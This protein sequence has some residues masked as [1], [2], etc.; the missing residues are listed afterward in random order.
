MEHQKYDWFLTLVISVD[1]RKPTE[2]AIM[3]KCKDQIRQFE[4]RR[5]DDTAPPPL[6]YQTKRVKHVNAF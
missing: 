5:N 4:E 3:A 2:A 6:K 1:H